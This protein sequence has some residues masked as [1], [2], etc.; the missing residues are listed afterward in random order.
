MRFHSVMIFNALLIYLFMFLLGNNG[1]VG[2][3]AFTVLESFKLG[4]G[5]IRNPLLVVMV[6]S[7]QKERNKQNK[8]KR[9]HMSGHTINSSCTRRQ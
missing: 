3:S 8:N 2:I 6:E 7:K 1:N 5:S 9:E 4:D